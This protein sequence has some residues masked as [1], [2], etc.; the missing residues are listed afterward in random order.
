MAAEHGNTYAAKNRKVRQEALRENLQGN[1]YLQ[2]MHKILN[3]PWTGIEITDVVI[4][5]KVVKEMRKFNHT[6]EYK[7]KCDIYAALLKKCLPD[8]KQ[9]EGIVTHEHNLKDKR[10]IEQVADALGIPPAD[11]FAD[12]KI[13]DLEERRKA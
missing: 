10:Q 9:I 4:D 2:Q 1:K 8:L 5:G 6:A 3:K 12:P 11:L 13:I 7:A